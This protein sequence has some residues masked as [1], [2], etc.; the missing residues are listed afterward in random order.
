ME[1][2]GKQYKDL[3]FLGAIWN[4]VL[5]LGSLT[6]FRLSMRMLFGKSGMTNKLTATLPLRF[7]YIAIAI[8]GWG[9]YMVSKDLKQNRGIIKMGVVAKLIIF[10]CFVYYWIQKKLTFFPVMLASVDVAFS[11]L[12]TYF[13]RDERFKKD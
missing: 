6:F 12:F 10:I 8:F 3:F 7:F 2:T 1:I 5:G 9:Y 13:L 4:V 11:A